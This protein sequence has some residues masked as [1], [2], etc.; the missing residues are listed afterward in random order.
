MKA[1]HWA[2]H[3]GRHEGDLVHYITEEDGQEIGMIW[4]ADYA[5]LAAAAPMLL[6]ALRYLAEKHLPSDLDP[7]LE[8]SGWD[9]M[10][11]DRDAIM[12]ARA[13]I[14]KATGQA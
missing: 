12:A 4:N 8:D 3:E 9:E 6:E 10:R 5:K 2:T 13:A 11:I 14:A 7:E 1:N